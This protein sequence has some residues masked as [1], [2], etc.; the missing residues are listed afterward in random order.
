VMAWRVMPRFRPL[1]GTG[2]TGLASGSHNGSYRQLAPV[3]P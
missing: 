3:S 2:I 1:A